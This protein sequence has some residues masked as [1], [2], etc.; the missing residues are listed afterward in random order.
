MVGNVILIIFICFTINSIAIGH[1]M[2]QNDIDD[3]SNSRIK[4]YLKDLK[5]DNITYYSYH[6]HV[7]FLQNDSKQRNEANQLRNQFLAKFNVSNCNDHCETW[8]PRICHWNLNMSPVGPHPIGSWG[9]YIPLEQFTQT[10]SFISTYHGNLTVLIHPNSGRPKIDHLINGLWIKSILRLNEIRQAF[11]S[12]DDDNDGLIRTKDLP[13]IFKQFGENLQS[14]IIE[15]DELKHLLDQN[16]INDSDQITVTQFL[17]LIACKVN[18]DDNI[19][20]L[21]E[22]FNIFDPTN[23]GFIT[24]KDLLRVMQSIG[25]NIS[26]ADAQEMIRHADRDLSGK[27]NFAEFIEMIRYS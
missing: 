18:V 4:P 2:R 20:E 23:T 14:F 6:I 16:N 7:Y 24:M 25:E 8:C 17:T 13:T 5:F 21:Q 9:V 26:E 3:V 10:I 12:V 27:I 15:E 19:E 1:F 11:S 22:A